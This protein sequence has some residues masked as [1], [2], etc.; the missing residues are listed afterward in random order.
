VI[1]WKPLRSPKAWFL[2]VLFALQSGVFYSLTTWLVARY[3]EA[4]SS[5]VEA[6]GLA[7]VFMFA[8][9]GGA[10][11]APVLMRRV[12]RIHYLLMSINATVGLSIV[13]VVL[14]PQQLPL[15]VCTVLGM[16]L[17]SM[18]AIGFYGFSD[19]IGDDGIALCCAWVIFE[20]ITYRF[21]ATD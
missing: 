11:L 19:G 3:E 15:L 20:K 5:L 9:I 18:F 21:S 7:S 1:A 16:A 10:F 12:T 6:S 8:G 13:C 17:T 14:W 4:S 2:T